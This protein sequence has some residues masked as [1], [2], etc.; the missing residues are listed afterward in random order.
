MASLPDITVML[1][2]SQLDQIIRVNCFAKCEH[3]DIQSAT[4]NLKRIAIGKSGDCM[5]FEPAT[6]K[7]TD[8]LKRE[9][10]P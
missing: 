5:R 7:T 1:D 10:A 8:A 2:T 6:T 9:L 4:C 3:R